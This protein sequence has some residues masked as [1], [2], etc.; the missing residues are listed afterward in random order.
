LDEDGY[1]VSDGDCDDANPDRN[2]GATDVP[3]DGIDQD[4]DPST[5]DDDLDE[6]G[7]GV[8]DEDCD[9]AN[10]DRNPGA[11]DVPDDGI[12][13]DC[14]GIDATA[15]TGEPS[16]EASTEP[17]EEDT[18]NTDIN[19]SDLTDKDQGCSIISE[20]DMS[21]LMVLFALIG[22]RRRR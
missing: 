6:D 8:S 22:V 15:D 12:D 17:L 3:D 11:T 1:G 20:T 10:P 4:C 5:A 19:E 13:Q 21:L 18:A 16:S 9:D 2:P 14:D 7:Y